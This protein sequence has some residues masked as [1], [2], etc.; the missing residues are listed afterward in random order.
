VSTAPPPTTSSAEPEP[1]IPTYALAPSSKVTLSGKRAGKPFSGSIA[2]LSGT[3]KLN[4]N[5]IEGSALD[6]ALESASL[7]ADDDA[8]AVQLRSDALLDAERY[9]Q[10]T[11]VST[12]IADAEGKKPEAPHTI[13]GN[14]TFH[15]VLK[16][17]RAG[18]HIEL[19]DEALQLRF[20]LVIHRK[21]FGLADADLADEVQLEFD[22][23]FRRQ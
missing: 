11:F 17:M 4:G 20:K 13:T 22:L 19:T 18:V 9:A 12:R 1:T 6:L 2:G 7:R 23:Q 15:G 3:F 10:T 5:V 21:D 14:L 8:L 16:S